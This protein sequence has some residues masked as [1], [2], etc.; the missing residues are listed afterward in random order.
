MPSQ[1]ALHHG[2]QG[3]NVFGND[4]PQN[5][6]VDAKVFMTNVVA[7]ASYLAPRL[8]WEIREPVVG[9]APHSLGYC[10]NR[11]GSD[12]TN[13]RII[14]KGVQRRTSLDLVQDCDLGKAVA[15]R[16]RRVLQRYETRMASRSMLSFISG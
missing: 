5:G 12:T 2:L 1:H 6:L 13:D 8:S 9:N 16:N 14:P 10:L 7:D 3:M 15:N 11:I 4:L